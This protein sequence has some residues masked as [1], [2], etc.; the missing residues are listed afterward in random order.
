MKTITLSLIIAALLSGC[1]SKGDILERNVSP[2]QN[3]RL[4][5]TEKPIQISGTLEKVK[6]GYDYVNLSDTWY[7]H[8]KVNI[9]S[10]SVLD[11]YLDGNF[12]GE[13]SGTW[14]NRP[15][16]ANCS[17]KPSTRN[18]TDVRCIIFIENEKTVTLT[19]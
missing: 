19:F 13:V 2:A 3:Y 5:N 15:V 1:A 9:D 6:A 18:W 12:F 11:G 4:A 8:L 16:S 17:G 10:Q 14:D 7:N